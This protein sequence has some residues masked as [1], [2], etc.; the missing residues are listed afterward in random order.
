MNGST[1]KR[2]H[3][4]NS[5]VDNL[6][7]EETISRVEEIIFRRKPTQHV[8]INAN[9]L[10]LMQKDVALR[11]I[12]N[13]SELINADGASVLLAGKILGK[14]L[15]ERVT[16]IDLF[17]ELLE[18][19]EKKDYRPYFFG[20]TQEVIEEVVNFIKKKYPNIDIA[21]YRNGYF[22]ALNSDEIVKQISD[23]KADLLFVGFSSPQKEYW[24]NDHLEQMNVPFVMGVG[25]SFD[26]VAGKTKR[27][28]KLW[29]KLG[30]EWL[31]RFIQEPR[32]MFKRYI[33]G[34]LKFL[35]YVGKERLTN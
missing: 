34:N 16:G 1:S 9:K 22:D 18:K 4:L 19:C 31:F 6:S 3:F 32:R 11:T 15:V 5:N 24:I 23:S 2:I 20:A 8:V 14:P 25:G 33:I 27:A 30:M 17:L 12:V 10:N 29:Q 21:G 26:V 7:M 13:N 28:P 35:Y